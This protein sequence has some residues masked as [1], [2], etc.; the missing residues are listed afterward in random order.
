MATVCTDTSRPGLTCSS[1]GPV[2]Y[3]RGAVPTPRAP[4]PLGLA[5]PVANPEA[6]TQIWATGEML[7]KALAVSDLTGAGV[8]YA[9]SVK[10]FDEALLRKQRAGGRRIVSIENGSVAGGFGEAIGADVRFGWPDAFVP[11]GSVVELERRYGLDAESIAARLGSDVS[12]AENRTM[13]KNS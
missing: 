4:L 3:P 6:K 9:R 12:A 7:E 10:P 11:H 5:V 2:R 1:G 8:V 13:L